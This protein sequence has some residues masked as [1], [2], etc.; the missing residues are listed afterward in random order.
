MVSLSPRRLPF[1]AK[2]LVA[3]L[4]PPRK[5][6]W[7]YI[8]TA[9]PGDAEMAGRI[10]AHRSRRGAFWRIIKPPRALATVLQ[11][12]STGAGIEGGADDVELIGCFVSAIP[13]PTIWSPSLNKRD[14]RSEAQCRRW[15]SGA[16]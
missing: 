10:T 2:T 11:S 8:A 7:N 13:K 5:S 14:G 1:C 3:G 6:L 16:D 12:S 15:W 9:E 4:P